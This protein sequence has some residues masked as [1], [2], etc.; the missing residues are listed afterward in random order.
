MPQTP[1]VAQK[2]PST[3]CSGLVNVK[4]SY[5]LLL[6]SSELRM[7]VKQN[8]PHLSFVHR[9]HPGP[10]GCWGEICVVIILWSIFKYPAS[11]VL[12][13]FLLSIFTWSSVLEN[14]YG[15]KK[16]FEFV[17]ELKSSVSLSSAILNRSVQMPRFHVFSPRDRW[18]AGATSISAIVCR[19]FPCLEN[20][21]YPVNGILRQ[22]ESPFW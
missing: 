10:R 20:L 11:S 15:G 14:A 1:K 3:V 2:L 13:F 12:N 17:S 18:R 6:I 8:K 4:L 19:Y 7:L 22:I 9:L 21:H 16:L 5:N